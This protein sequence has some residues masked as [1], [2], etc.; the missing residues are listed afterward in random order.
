MDTMLILNSIIKKLS[1]ALKGLKKISND[2]DTIKAAVSQDSKQN[3]EYSF[4]E[5]Y[6]SNTFLKVKANLFKSEKVM[7]SFV[8]KSNPQ[9]IRSIDCFLTFGEALLL[10][11]AAK[12]TLLKKCAA[13]KAKGNQYPAE[14]YT[15]PFGGVNEVA[16]K[17]RKLRNDGK[18]LSRY[19]KIGAGSKSE[20]IFTAESRAGHSNDKG[21]IVP[22]KGKAELTIRVPM[23]YKDLLIMGK[24]I[25][26]NIMAYLS[27]Q[28]AHNAFKSEYKGYEQEPNTT[29]NQPY[30]QTVY[31]PQAVPQMAQTY[32]SQNY[33]S[34]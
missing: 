25:D 33:Y 7:F 15:S 29:Q 24:L 20:I 18:A 30:E 14:S 5:M 10:A 21:L 11:E 28:Y 32:N 3:I 9:N 6:S 17:K 31:I 19:F 4:F 8:D 16:C 34:A 27:S 22:E 13:E 2:V 1:N 23:G 26:A 12:G